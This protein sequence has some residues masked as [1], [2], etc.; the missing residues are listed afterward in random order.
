MSRRRAPPGGAAWSGVPLG[1]HSASGSRFSFDFGG[2]APG[3][4]LQ[5]QA[6]FSETD[7]WQCRARR[8]LGARRGISS[9]SSAR[10]ALTS[11]LRA[12]ADLEEPELRMADEGKG[13]GG[14]GA[15][16]AR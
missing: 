13:Q 16:S 11:V 5:S 15:S 10:L 2:S 14:V 8:G 7:A 3:Q 12:T 1:S 6:T 4:S 9:A